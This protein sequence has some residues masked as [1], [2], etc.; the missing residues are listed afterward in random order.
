ML[1]TIGAVV[2]GYVAIFVM[3]FGTFSLAFLALGVNGAFQPGTYDVTPVW[4][5]VSFVLTFVAAVIGGLVSVIISDDPKVP[6][7]LAIVVI[8]LG[9]ITAIQIMSADPAVVTRGGEVE[10]IEAMMSAK[11]PIWV[12]LLN[13]IIGAIG[14]MVGARLKRP[15]PSV[16]RA[17]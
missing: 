7:A 4:L 1:R 17:V 8:V 9:V 6:R 12:A 2:G 14:V 13:P 11:Q 16:A 3:L 5:I 15:R 10:N